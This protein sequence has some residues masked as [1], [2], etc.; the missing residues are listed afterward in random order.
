ML[1]EV[2]N[3]IIDEITDKSVVGDDPFKEYD[4]L[5]KFAIYASDGVE[6]KPSIHDE[7]RFGAK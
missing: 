3:L 4:D 1:L 5:K 6:I 7:H 2:S